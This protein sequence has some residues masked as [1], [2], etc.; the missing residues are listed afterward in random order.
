MI[1]TIFCPQSKIGAGKTLSGIFG[2]GPTDYT[3][4]FL[5]LN[6]TDGNQAYGVHQCPVSN[7]I[8]G[9]VQ[10]AAQGLLTLAP[11]VPAWP[12]GDVSA[13]QDA[14]EAANYVLTLDP[15]NPPPIIAGQMIIALDVD[16]R[17]L[18]AAC[19]LDRTQ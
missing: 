1:L 17:Q 6:W 10:A 15:D 16:A 9:A 13:A 12:V 4:S 18:A 11:Y 19:G 7:P 3:D 5:S 8:A 14:I 2:L